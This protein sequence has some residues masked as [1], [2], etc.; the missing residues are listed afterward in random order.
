MK[1]ILA[2]VLSLCSFSFAQCPVGTPPAFTSASSATF[3]E[4]SAGSFAV[5]ASGTPAPTFSETGA[6]PSGVSFTATGLQGTPADGTAGTYKITLKAT[7]GVSPDAAQAFT[8]TVNADV[9]SGGQWLPTAAPLSWAWWLSNVPPA[10]NLP[11]QSVIDSDG[12]DTPAS[13]VAAMH[14]QGKKWICYVDVGTWEPGRPDASKF[15]ASV[16]GSSVDGFASEKWLDIRQQ[17]ILLPLMSARIQSCKNK[18]ADAVEPDDV[19]G[20]TNSPGFPFTAAD[21]LSYNK[22]IAGMVHSFGMSVALKNDGDQVKQL[23]PFFDFQIAEQCVQYGE[24]NL[25]APFT[26][27]NKAVFAAEYKGSASTVCPKLNAISFDGIVTN[28]DLTGKLTSCR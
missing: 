13:T 4:L 26:S 24:C 28:V 3:T 20:Y 2:V 9:V 15:P 14:A 11:A 25:Y 7:N 12:V 6:L 18:G 27:A 10:N 19:D 16:K 23:Q 1:T 5:T 17:S 21:Q 8:L 22:A